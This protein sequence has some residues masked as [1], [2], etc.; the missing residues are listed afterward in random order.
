[1]E[2]SRKQT[3]EELEAIKAF[4]EEESG[5]TPICLDKAI[6]YLRED[7]REGRA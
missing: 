4:F 5:A 7:I 6:Q 1:M 2:M 3:I